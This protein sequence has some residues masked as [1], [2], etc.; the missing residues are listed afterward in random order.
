[1]FKK[2][3][4]VIILLLGIGV[5]WFLRGGSIPKIEVAE[6]PNKALKENVSNYP[7]VYDAVFKRDAQELRGQNNPIYTG[8]IT[9]DGKPELIFITVGEGCA[10]CHAENLYIFQEEKELLKLE[11]DDPFF[12]P[13]PAIRGFLVTE[14]IRRLDDGGYCCPISFQ[15]TVYIWDGETFRKK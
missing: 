6:Q 4:P 10:S 8:D 11:L 12:R 5:G 3:L 13:L 9:R 7:E 15:N 14:P 1:M 2:A